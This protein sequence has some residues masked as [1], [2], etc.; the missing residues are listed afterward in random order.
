MQYRTL[1]SSGLTV[2]AIGFGA[3]HIGDPSLVESEVAALLGGL[4]DDGV[5]LFDTARSYGLSE[6]RI[7]R[8]LA[9]RRAEIVLSTK[10]GYGIEGF[11]DWTAEIVRPAVER[12]LSMLRTDV[13]DVVHLH[14]CPLEVLQR[15]DVVAALQRCVEQGKVRVA[16]YSGDNEPAEWAAASGAF[17][18]VQTSVSLFDQHAIDNAVRLAEARGV[19]VIAKRP[20]GN[21]PWR[22]E[23]RPQGSDAEEYW[24]RWQAMGIE[25]GELSWDELAMRFTLSVPG[26]SSAIV[27]SRSLAHMRQNIAAAAK[28]PLSDDVV[29]AIRGAFRAE[30]RGKI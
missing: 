8:H 2:S 29:Q 9:S 22:F 18:A 23:A 27:G 1:G 16:A 4:V 30:W 24:D 7:G 26:V 12:A 17:G 28:G 6:E 21:A 3:G 13:I 14:S 11:E 20:L 19:G 15:G 10:I 25:R 5:T